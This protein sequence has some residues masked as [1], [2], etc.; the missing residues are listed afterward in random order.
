MLP[1]LPIEAVYVLPFDIDGT[2][3]VLQDARREIIGTGNREVC[4]ALL[5]LMIR[6]RAAG[7]FERT[8]ELTHADVHSAIVI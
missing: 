8:P 6:A 2:I 4:M 7:S 1:Q 5:D 3:Y